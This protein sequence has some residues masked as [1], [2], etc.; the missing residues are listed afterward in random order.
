MFSRGGGGIKPVYFK[1]NI[2]TNPCDLAVPCNKPGI[3]IKNG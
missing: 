3:G 2:L 1:K